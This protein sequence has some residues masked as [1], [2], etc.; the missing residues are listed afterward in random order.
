M[1]MVS[2]KLQ[3][4]ARTTGEDSAHTDKEK[5]GECLDTT[6]YFRLIPPAVWILA[7]LDVDK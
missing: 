1:Q 5:E 7:S 4:N 6:C 3:W 2:Q